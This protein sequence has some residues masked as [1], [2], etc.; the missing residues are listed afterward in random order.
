[1][2][3][4]SKKFLE[5]KFITITLHP[6]IDKNKERRDLYHKSYTTN[7]M[8]LGRHMATGRLPEPKRQLLDSFCR[9][10]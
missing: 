5:M 6:E 9:R 1:M 10:R 8:L 4:I 2:H 3:T 7:D